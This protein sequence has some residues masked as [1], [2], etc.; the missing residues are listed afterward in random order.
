MIYFYKKMYSPVGELTLVANEEGL[1]AILWENDKPNRVRLG[2][3]TEDNIQ[4]MLLATEQ[5]LNDYFAGKL[6]K[7]NLKLNFNGT[8]FQKKVWNALLTIPFGETRS[9]GQIATQ[10]NHPRA[11]RA[12][13]AANGKNPLSIIAPCHRVIGANGTLTGFA[14]GLKIKS[15]LLDIEKNSIR[16]GTV[17]NSF[18]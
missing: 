16:V 14:G 11:V 12:V 4:P 7:F 13:G 18:F 9:Y 10:I 17:D 1:T 6:K 3:L 8:E 15:Y 2:E 5:Q